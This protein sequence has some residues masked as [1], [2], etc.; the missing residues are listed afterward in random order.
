MILPQVLRTP[1]AFALVLGILVFIHELGHYLAARWR[2]VHVEV[3]SIGFGRPLL[4]WHDR[5]GTEWRLCMLPLG[6]Y[7]RPHG[8]EGPGEASPE[9]QAK[10]L[11]GRTFHDKSVGSRAIV[12]LAGPVFNF[13]LA[14]VLFTALFAAVGRPSSAPLASMP[15]IIGEVVANG[16]ARSAGLLAGDRIERV[17]STPTG[18][19]VEVQRLVSAAPGQRLELQ[20]RRG[21]GDVTIPVTVGGGGKPGTGV[22]GV[23]FTAPPTKRLPVGRA[24][25]AGVDETWS[26]SVQTLDGIWQMITGR[27]ST[28]GLGGPLRIAQLS[29]QVAELGIASMVSFIALLSINLGLINL[30][31]IPV[32]DG[33]RL[34]FYA[35][36]AIRGRPV[37]RTVQDFSFRAGFALIACLFLFVTFNDLSH[38]G[39]FQWVSHRVG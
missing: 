2:G 39:L 26:V 35:L 37:P 27:Q 22:I 6:G 29:G 5:V 24:V 36:E 7:V 15:P 4:R 32:L 11:P 19:I 17:G 21:G 20:V 33:G 31:P 25:V 38:L 23:M 14:I 13:L 1:L 12:I 28:A 30:F 8:F 9:A 3:F 18:T 16:P 10:W 34:V